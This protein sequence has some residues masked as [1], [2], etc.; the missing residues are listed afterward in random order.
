MAV[1]FATLVTNL[2]SLA[3][4]RLRNR[5]FLTYRLFFSQRCKTRENFTFEQFHR[6]TTAR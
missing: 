6:C 1:H 2:F 3:G 5:R 4:V